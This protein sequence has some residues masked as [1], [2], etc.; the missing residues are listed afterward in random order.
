MSVLLTQA[1]QRLVRE[2]DLRI[3]IAFAGA[4]ILL[5][6][7]IKTVPGASR[8][9]LGAADWL[10]AVGNAPGFCLALNDVV[11]RA[12]KA[13]ALKDA[14][15]HAANDARV[16]DALRSSGWSGAT[17]DSRADQILQAY[18]QTAGEGGGTIDLW[19]V[20]DP[21]LYHRVTGELIQKAAS[22]IGSTAVLVT[23]PEEAE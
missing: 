15:A 22:T 11:G 3:F 5:P 14:F 2:S 6:D 4:P 1:L 13:K 10:Q 23:F 7:W 21:G 9:Y 19:T 17:G 12:K 18:A 20:A 8:C 16:E